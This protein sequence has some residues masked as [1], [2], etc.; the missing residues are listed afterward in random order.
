MEL[1]TEKCFLLREHLAMRKENEYEKSTISCL[2]IM[3]Y[4]VSGRMWERRAC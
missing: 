1:V 2:Y 4:D 3:C